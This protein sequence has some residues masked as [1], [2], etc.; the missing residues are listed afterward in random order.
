MPIERN[1]VIGRGGEREKE[2]INGFGCEKT[3]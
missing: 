3:V 1:K 2:R